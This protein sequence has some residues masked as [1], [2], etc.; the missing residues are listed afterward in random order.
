M[1]YPTVGFYLSVYIDLTANKGA[2]RPDNTKT[3]KTEAIQGASLGGLFFAL[4]MRS[5]QRLLA[6]YASVGML[7]LCFPYWERVYFE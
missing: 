5:Y 7:S 3:R 1:T 6:P 4:E 2:E